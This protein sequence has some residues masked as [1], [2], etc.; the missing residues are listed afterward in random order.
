MKRVRSGKDWPAPLQSDDRVYAIDQ[1]ACVYVPHVGWTRPSTQVSVQNSDRAD[2]NIHGNRGSDT[3]FNFAS[4]PD[5]KKDSLSDA[6]LEVADEY[7]VKC[8]VHP[9]MNAYIHVMPTPYVAITSEKDD[10]G[11]P[12]GEAT[13]DDV[14]SGTYELVCWHEGMLSTLVVVDGKPSS[15]N[16]S[17]DQI[18]TERVPVEAGKRAEVVFVLEHK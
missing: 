16:Y 18:K 14:P 4:E 11:A 7:F 2:H 10:G 15:Y 3:K 5:T 12:A 13:L 6:F 8:D 9:W 1:K 17:P